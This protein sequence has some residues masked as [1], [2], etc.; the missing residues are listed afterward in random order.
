MTYRSKERGSAMTDLWY[1]WVYGSPRCHISWMV[2]SEDLLE[3]QYR[4]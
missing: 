1:R 2:V 3:L 4:T